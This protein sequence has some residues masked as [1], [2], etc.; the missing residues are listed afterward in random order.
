MNFD[1]AFDELQISEGGYS[2]HPDDTGGATMYGVT[3]R[4]ARA[5]GYAGDMRALPLA[6]AKTVARADY[7][8]KFQCDQLGPVLGFQVF[9]AAYNGGPAAKW[10]QRAVGATEDGVIGAKT[11]G[12]LRGA[13][14]IKVMARFNAYR[15]QYL[16]GL[17][18]WPSFGKG[19]ARRIAEN[20]LL[21]AA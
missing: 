20:L 21:G 11:I 5:R 9:D 7:W 1:E 2:D 8:D 16:A 3:E 17:A 19:W 18:V 10:L 15:Q 12:A 4:V 13:D 6:F 14:P